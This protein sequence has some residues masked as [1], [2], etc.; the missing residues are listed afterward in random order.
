[1]GRIALNGFHH[2]KVAIFAIW[3]ANT[4]APRLRMAAIDVGEVIDDTVVGNRPIKALI[5]KSTW[6]GE[7][8]IRK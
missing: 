7:A 4:P 6:Y 2:L 1:M 3:H 8:A 5:E